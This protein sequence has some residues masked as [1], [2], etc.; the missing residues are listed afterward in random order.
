[1]SLTLHFHQGHACH[2]LMHSVSAMEC[3]TKQDWFITVQR[4][5][6]QH[7]TPSDSNM[8]AVQVLGVWYEKSE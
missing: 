3:S 4:H 1:M 8:P 2:G 6:V 7:L 5:A